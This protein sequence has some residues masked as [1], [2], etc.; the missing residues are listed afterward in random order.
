MLQEPPEDVKNYLNL[1]VWGELQE[2]EFTKLS[3]NK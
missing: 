3:L 1:Q 2:K